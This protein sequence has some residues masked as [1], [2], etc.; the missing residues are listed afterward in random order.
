[1]DDEMDLYLSR[2][3]KNA[4]ARCQPPA[5]GKERLFRAIIS[6][7]WRSIRRSAS[8]PQVP[9]EFRPSDQVVFLPSNL[10]QTSFTLSLAWPVHIGTVNSGTH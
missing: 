1:M 3:L 7:R 8:S 5:R 6:P 4:T 9:K 2:C 10:M